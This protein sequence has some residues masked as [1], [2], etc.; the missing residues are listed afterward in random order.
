MSVCVLA[1]EILILTSKPLKFTRLHKGQ[2]FLFI[3]ILT[4]LLPSAYTSIWH[5][6]NALNKYFRIVEIT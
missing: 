5:I 2:R 1:K 3:L 4:S 6:K